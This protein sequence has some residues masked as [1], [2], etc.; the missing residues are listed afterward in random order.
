MYA[1]IDGDVRLLTPDLAGP[2]GLAFSPDEQ[3]LYIGNWERDRSVIMRYEVTAEGRLAGDDI[4]VDLSDADGEHSI[5]GIKVDE[6]GRLYVCGPGGIW[7]IAPDGRRLGQLQLPEHP[8]NLAWGDA[9]GRTL[10]V[11]AQT[12]IYR[13]PL[14][15]RGIRPE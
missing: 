7:I 2:N 3:V 9:E 4:L 15:T 5:D 1:V 12:S 11:T 8:H 6:H 10:Y 14:R 13:I